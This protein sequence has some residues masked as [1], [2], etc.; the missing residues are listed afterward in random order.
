[1]KTDHKQNSFKYVFSIIIPAFNEEFRIEKS[2]EKIFST[3]KGASYELILID[4][5]SSDNTWKILTQ[6]KNSYSDIKII[7]LKENRGKGF[8]IKTGFQNA[9]GKYILMTDADLSTPI[10]TLFE[11]ETNLNKY[12]VLI[13]SRIINSEKTVSHGPI[14]RKILR[15]ISR[16]IRKILFN[17]DI[18]DTQCGFKIFRNQVA[19]EIAHKMT[20]DR[21]G[22]DLE[23]III[24]K[25][26][27]YKIKEIPVSW[28][29]DGEHSKIH[30]FKDSYKTL[31]EWLKI[32][33]NLLFHKY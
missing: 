23:K 5:G 17:I 3:L 20:I 33:L 6:I 19:K 11:L 4:D 24:A 15:K 29:F 16:I 9:D 28:I 10:E 2:V 21:Y 7:K 30:L 18:N 8:A 32:K 14:S 22:A 1:M 13:G 27:G 12:D 26:L 31:K 25:K